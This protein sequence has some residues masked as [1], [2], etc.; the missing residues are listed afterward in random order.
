MAF[1]DV[2]PLREILHRA[3]VRYLTIRPTGFLLADDATPRRQ[4]EARIL[5]FGGARTLYRDR[6]PACRSLDGARPIHDSKLACGDC[7]SRESCTPQVRVDLLVDGR[8]YR[9][10][11]AHTSAKGFLIYDALLRRRGIPLERTI[12]SLAVVDRGSWG[13]VRFSSRD[14]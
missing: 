11:L 7:R 2:Q 1:D 5:G 4:I 6:K 9:L 10:L 8:P 13:E 14:S 12:H 3:L